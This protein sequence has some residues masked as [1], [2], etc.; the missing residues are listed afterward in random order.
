QHDGTPQDTIGSSY[1][2]V[3]SFHFYCLPLIINIIE[4]NPL[5]V[6]RPPTLF[7]RILLENEIFFAPRK[8]KIFIKTEYEHMSFNSAF[9]ILLDFSRN[10]NTL[11]RPDKMYNLPFLYIIYIFYHLSSEYYRTKITELNFI[12]KD[13]S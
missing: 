3:K 7:S 5:P 6:V 13:V 1:E 9:P 11:Q 8:R 10:F 2:I 4:I 12:C